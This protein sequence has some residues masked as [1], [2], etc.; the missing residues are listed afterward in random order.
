MNRIPLV[1][2][3]L[4]A[5]SGEYEAASAKITAKKNTTA[6][7]MP[8]RI[9]RIHIISCGVVLGD[10]NLVPLS[11]LAMFVTKCSWV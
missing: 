4:R 5:T 10:L 8:P 6:A 7:A 3:L 1:T 9:G 2:N 11:I